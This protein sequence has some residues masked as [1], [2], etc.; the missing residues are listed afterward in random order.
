MKRTALLLSTVLL[1]GL[2]AAPP[3]LAAPTV[4]VAVAKVKASPAKRS[5]SC[6]TTVGFSA[7]VTA[8]G[9][10]TVRYR[11][12]RGDG[13]KS[14]IKSFHVNGARKVPVKDRQTFD[15]DASGWQAVQ[16]LG[17]K[18][19]SAKA[20]FRVSCTGTPQVW[21]DTRPLPS[22]PG[23]PLVAAA[24]VDV[25][26]ATYSGACP[27]TATFTGTIQ[28]SR[29]PAKVDY[30]WIDSATG[31]GRRESISFA[32]GGPRS[33]L[34]TLPMGVGASTSGWK[35]IDLL[36][37]GSHDSG[38]ATYQVTCTGST[39]PPS[40]PPPPLPGQMPKAR[41]LELNPVD[42]A[43]SCAEPVQHWAIGEISLPPGPAQKVTYFWKLDSTQWSSQELDFPADTQPRVRNVVVNWKFTAKDAGTH[44]IVLMP[45]GGAPAERKFTFSCTPGPDPDPANVRIA[46]TLSPLYRGQCDRSVSLNA[47]AMV[48]SDQDTDLSYRLVVDGKPNRTKTVKLTR[49]KGQKIDDFWTFD[50]KAS[51]TGVLRFEV[52][53]ANKPIKHAAYVWTC[54]PQ[55][56]SAG[57]VRITE[58]TSM[59]YRG[60]CDVP[61]YTTAHAELS[62]SPG[63]GIS[64]RWVIDGRP[65]TTYTTTTEGSGRAGVQA[66]YWHRPERKSGNVD[67]EVLDHNKPIMQ[68]GYPVTCE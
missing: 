28:V 37:P 58:L 62:A 17:R 59:A 64:Y 42:Y 57:P 25:T 34:I 56:T 26:P 15:R 51:G 67:L 16:V 18:G 40:E 43:G 3:A 12:V 2:L 6:P 55:D 22:E 20:R 14:A 38:R 9:K 68:V 7:V 50:P 52:L 32:A 46:Y 47:E 39:P 33:R 54:V 11:W 49:G 61:P 63:T 35:A 53:N 36:N 44:A 23:E 24:D 19:L 60:D 27:T 10:G 48:F 1:S 29:T 4:K 45:Q 30:R 21:D 8:K 66:A 5:G 13:S 65:T 41:I 31:E